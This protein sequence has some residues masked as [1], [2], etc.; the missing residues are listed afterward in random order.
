[1][2]TLALIA[3]DGKKDAMVTFCHRHLS[4]LQSLKLV[5]TGTTGGRIADAT[6]L[7]V[8]RPSIAVPLGFQRW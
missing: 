2:P 8:E 4:I 1:M 5:G 3:H 7:N 6:G